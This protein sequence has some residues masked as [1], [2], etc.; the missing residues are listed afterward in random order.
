MG[1]DISIVKSHL[2]PVVLGSTLS[3]D[4]AQNQRRGPGVGG[5][6]GI[7]I[8]PGCGNGLGTGLGGTGGPGLG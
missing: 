3:Y 5:G 6:V 4:K 8:G 7:G 2:H 1:S